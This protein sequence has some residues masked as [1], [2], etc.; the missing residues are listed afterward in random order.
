MKTGSLP[1]A[2]LIPPPPRVL[3]AHI[4]RRA[5]ADPR[6][7]FWWICCLVLCL[8][9]LAFAATGLH[10]WQREIKLVRHGVTVDA[11]IQAVTYVARRGASF[12]PSNPVRLEFPWRDGIH[13]THDEH[14][15]EGYTRFVTVGDTVRIRVDPNDPENWT[16]LAEAMPLRDRV[17]PAT[18]TFPAVL[19]TL[20]A[21]VWQRARILSIWKNGQL[22]PALV[23]NSSVS[24]LAPLGRAIR[25][26]PAV[27]GDARVFTIHAGGHA[28]RQPGEAIDVL[29]RRAPAQLAVAA[30]FFA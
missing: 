20:I 6:A 22:T 27:D 7:R 10:E 24:A 8:I 14:P 18:L 29:A 26:T 1:D 5:W 9:A 19:A 15:L 16:A 4:R 23:L 2:S 11:Q 3:T 21:A 17:M 13:R 30:E 25:C 28:H 12:D